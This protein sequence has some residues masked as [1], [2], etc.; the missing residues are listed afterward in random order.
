MS[1]PN[2]WKWSSC[3]RYYGES[4]YPPSLLDAHYLLNM[5]SPDR[6]NAEERFKE[7]NERSN[8]D[9]CLEDHGDSTLRLSDDEAREEIRKCLGRLEIPQVKCLPNMERDKV[10][11]R[12]KRIDGVSQMQAAR[13]LGVAV[14]F[15][16]R[17][18]G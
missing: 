2:H 7:F 4:V 6:S 9:I 16:C 12:V 13:I 11:K 18:K 3:L 5:F 17:V 10:L 15:L 8:Q 14:Y 1:K